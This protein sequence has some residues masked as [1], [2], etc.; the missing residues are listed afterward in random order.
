MTGARNKIATRHRMAFRFQIEARAQKP[1]QEATKE[2]G[3]KVIKP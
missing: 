1:T 2:K 3:L